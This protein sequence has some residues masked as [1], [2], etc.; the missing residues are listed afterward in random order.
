MGARVGRP[1]A[2]QGLWEDRFIGGMGGGPESRGV[3]R[4]TQANNCRPIPED[5]MSGG[6]E[7]LDIARDGHRLD[8]LTGQ[9]V[10]TAPDLEP[11]VAVV[12][13]YAEDD[14]PITRNWVGA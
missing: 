13:P 7:G 10:R 5:G 3:S 6:T 8:G 1:V 11:R 14:A 4:S 12:P 9:P 2:S